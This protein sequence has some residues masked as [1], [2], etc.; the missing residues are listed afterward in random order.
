MS[1]SHNITASNSGRNLAV[2]Y[3]QAMEA[4]VELADAAEWYCKC[5][6]KVVAR[7]P[8]HGL[9]E[10]RE[11]YRKAYGIARA[12]QTM[13]QDEPPRNFYLDFTDV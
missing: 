5:L 11:A 13:E 10:A 9:T 6:R 12:L 3:E 1:R 2:A 4:L 7:E 8:V